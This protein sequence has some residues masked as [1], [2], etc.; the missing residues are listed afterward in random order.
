MVMDW[1]GT[2]GVVTKPP[3]IIGIMV[4]VPYGY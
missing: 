3:V 4:H 1:A 2:K